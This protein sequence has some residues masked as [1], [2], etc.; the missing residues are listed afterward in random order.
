MGFLRQGK[1]THASIYMYEYVFIFFVIS[2]FAYI[3]YSIFLLF[4]AVCSEQAR[5]H[6]VC[7]DALEDM[8]EKELKEATAS[9]VEMT[10]FEIAER[11]ER[12]VLL[13]RC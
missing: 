10:W 8:L 6:R 5:M 3:L 13:Y 11:Y 4:P 12:Y 1:L 7:A 2:L 9:G